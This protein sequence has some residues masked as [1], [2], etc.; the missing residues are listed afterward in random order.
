MIYTLIIIIVLYLYLSSKRKKK[1]P[2]LD[3]KIRK[4]RETGIRP[5]DI[6]V[7]PEENE[8]CIKEI[9]KFFL[10]LQNLKSD[11]FRY[12]DCKKI[13]NDY[14]D[15]YQKLENYKYKSI[16]ISNSNGFQS[17]YFDLENLRNNWN[18]EY[19]HKTLINNKKYFDNIDGKSL[20][21]QQRIAVAVD[22]DN[23]LVLAG[24]GSGKTLVV[25]AKVKFLVEKK[26]IKPNEILLISFTKKAA[27]EMED[28][29]NRMIST[30]VQAYTFHRLGLEIITTSNRK[31][32]DV[33]EDMMPFIN[34]YFKENI[35]KNDQ[36]LKNIITF[37]GN[38]LYVP[39][40]LEKLDSVGEAYDFYKGLDLET[41]KS[42]VEK[43]GKR[44]KKDKITIQGEIVKSLE[45]V[46]IANFL[47]LNGVKYTY[48]K[49]YP[50]D[51]QDNYRKQ[52]RPDFY[53]DDYDIYIEHFGITQDN[54]A[55]WLSK[56]E[57]E[58]YLD[59]IRWKRMLHHEHGTKLLE[60]YSYFNTEGVL[61]K[62]LD[63]LLKTHGVVYKKVD[64]YEIYEN[65]LNQ[66]KNYSF[67]ELKSLIKTFITLFKSKGYSIDDFPRLVQENDKI[68]HAFLEDRANLFLKVIEPIFYQYEKMLKET[69]QI[70]FNDMIN[71][72]TKI[73]KNESE[74][75]YRYIIVDEYQ[76]I[77]FSRFNL[78]KEIKNKTNAKIMAVG[79]DW[80]SIYRF[81]GSDLDLFTNFNEY[82]GYSEL[83]KIEKTYRNAQELIDI[84][85]R[86]IM[87]NPKQI[88]KDLTSDKSL[89][90][91]IRI[92]GYDLS[93]D[94]AVKKAIDEIVERYSQDTEILILGRNNFD[95]DIL[96]GSDFFKIYKKKDTVTLFC[97]EYP[98]LKMPFLSVHRSKGLEADNV[99]VLN[100][101]NKLVG[102]PNQISD[103]PL[104]SLV[105]TN[106][107]GFVYGEERRLF[108]VALTRT[109]SSVYLIAPDR[110]Q[111]VFIKE[112]IEKFNICFEKSTLTASIQENPKCPFCLTGHLVIREK[113]TGTNFLGC[114]NFP[115]CEKT[116][117]EIEI[118]NNRIICNLCGGYMVKR[119]GRYG[120]FYGCSNYYYCKNTLQI[121]NQD[122]EDDLVIDHYLENKD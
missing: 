40:D 98:K 118:L 26:D 104:L 13:K 105:Q 76:D 111:S 7:S 28:R 121:D 68:A 79:D 122:A 86:F 8:A 42:K 75:N 44:L 59:G 31:R 80:Q 95:I 2:S 37:F 114:S 96:K 57:E 77:S 48:E 72:A 99:I 49:A 46:M 106:S 66:E 41:I 38:Y 52:Y 91:P 33:Y 78:I 50:H 107:D 85:G 63:G 35:L 3:S 102:F 74:L 94:I 36:E 67:M 100:L 29:I 120:E 83:L 108:Y 21:H 32:P 101:T 93:V 70:D 19:V 51:P 87:V 22:E 45:E 17:T 71:M 53:L 84:A 4:P 43:K 10:H 103:D 24:A 5:G 90:N 6:G 109:R 18:R 62:V 92:I 54:R 73:V 81:A 115:L 11:Y 82:L 56:I 69:K 34:N 117:N 23:N 113:D 14:F 15:L 1:S 20:D 61:Y 97:P 16:S 110:M 39:K 12:S 116:F 9:R 112:L 30:P 60:T 27:Q 89:R 47:Y 119:K 25:S 55:P 88:K 65:L 64:Y 58:K